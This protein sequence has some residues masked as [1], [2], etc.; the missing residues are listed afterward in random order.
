MSIALI[1]PTNILN[2][3]CYAI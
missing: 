2:V 3:Y 1:I